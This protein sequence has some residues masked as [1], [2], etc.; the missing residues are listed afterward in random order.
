[1]QAGIIF[2]SPCISWPRPTGFSANTTIGP[3]IQPIVCVKER[4]LLWLRRR[5]GQCH[6][7]SACKQAGR[8]AGWLSDT[9]SLCSDS[10][11][12]LPGQHY[13]VLHWQGEADRCT[14]YMC[15]TVKYLIF[16][17]VMMELKRSAVYYDEKT[18]H[19]H[20]ENQSKMILHILTW[21]SV[22]H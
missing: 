7:L 1:M 5:Y 14:E 16:L 11:L 6:V 2:S 10:G 9:C 12:V 20:T 8:W 3:L 22:S 13:R 19:K 18:K 21:S 17:S 15:C 4:L